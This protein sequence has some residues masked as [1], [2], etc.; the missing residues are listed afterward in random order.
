MRVRWVLWVLLAATLLLAASG[1]RNRSRN[2]KGDKVGA[3]Q[4][5]SAKSNRAAFTLRVYLD[6][7][8]SMQGYVNGATDFV[9]FV[10]DYV[11]SI[12]NTFSKNIDTND[13]YCRDVEF[14]FLDSVPHRDSSAYKDVVKLLRKENFK[15]TQSAIGTMIRKLLAQQ[16]KDVVSLFFTDGIFISKGN[17]VGRVAV[18][19][20]SQI[21]DLLTQQPIDMKFLYLESFFDGIYWPPKSNTRYVY[22]TRRPY[23]C[24]V[25]GDPHYMS[26]VAG[27]KFVRDL[28]G[29]D[30]CEMRT[31]LGVRELPITYSLLDNNT[32]AYSVV[33]HEGKLKLQVRGT[34]SNE[35]KLKVGFTVDSDLVDAEYLCDPKNYTVTPSDYEVVEIQPT[36]ERDTYRYHLYLVLKQG[37]EV[38]RETIA[39]ALKRPLPDWVDSCSENQGLKPI[40]GKTFGLNYLV[41]GIHSAYAQ[42]YGKYLAKME[43]E[44]KEK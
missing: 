10:S 19:V 15:T 38:P 13:I 30:S 36:K 6:N 9:A 43:I 21:A 44:V 2:N 33:K 1:C 4:I 34:E 26:A 40:A 18:N 27:N 42:H 24:W 12:A 29:L 35:F 7:S 3:S 5:D 20:K 25:L 23:C 11:T 32:G 31:Y 8:A 17:D 28:H 16:E 37:V 14:Y 39:I 41:D 22:K